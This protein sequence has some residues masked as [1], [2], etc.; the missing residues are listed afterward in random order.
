MTRRGSYAKGLAKREEIL[1]AALEVVAREGYRGS[2]VREIAAASGLSQAGLL[3]HFV[4]KDELFTEI[5]RRSDEVDMTLIGSTPGLRA[6]EG[7][8]L[9]LE[10]NIEVPGLVHL[11]VSFSAEATAPGHVAKEFFIE[12][13][14]RLQGYIV[15]DIRLRQTAGELP[16][17][18]NAESAAGSLIAMVAGLQSQWLLNPTIDMSALI[19]GTVEGWRKQK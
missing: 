8:S 7:I 17:N 13:S 1:D 11:F 18:L 10:R 16:T 14:T 15:D 5:L 9:A 2:S 6:L 12:R 19:R 4:S 3:H